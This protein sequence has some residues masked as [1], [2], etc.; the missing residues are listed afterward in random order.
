[1][2][3][4]T[5]KPCPFCGKAAKVNGLGWIY[6]PN[7]KCPVQPMTIKLFEVKDATILWNRRVK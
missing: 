6:C 4:I 7:E 5:L 3:E 1:M 2:K